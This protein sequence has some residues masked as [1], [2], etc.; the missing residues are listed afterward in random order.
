MDK[1]AYMIMGAFI[2][3]IIAFIIATNDEKKLSNKNNLSESTKKTE[4]VTHY[5]KSGGVELLK[6]SDNN[7]R[8]ENHNDFFVTIRRVEISNSHGAGETT[9]RVWNINAKSSYNLINIVYTNDGFY[10]YDS[11]GR[12]SGWIRAYE[13]H[14]F[15]EPK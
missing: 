12:L 1:R 5:G 11:L 14:Y 9:K 2:V 13:V 6:I 3:S 4:M 8:L 7:W 15:T 10:I